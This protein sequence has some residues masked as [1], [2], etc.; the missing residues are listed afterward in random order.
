MLFFWISTYKVIQ[1]Y[2][3]SQLNILIRIINSNKNIKLQEIISYHI[4]TKSAY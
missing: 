2:L 3:L 1:N 4:E